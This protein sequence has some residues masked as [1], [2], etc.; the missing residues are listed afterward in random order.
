[1]KKR[2]LIEAKQQTAIVEDYGL[3]FVHHPDIIEALG[4]TKTIIPNYPIGTKLNSN[5][6]IVGISIQYP[7]HYITENS[8][9]KLSSIHWERIPDCMLYPEST[10]P[11]NDEEDSL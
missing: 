10:T 6:T 7:T 3:D 1:M 2:I 11:L 5:R 9:G 8:S 4:I